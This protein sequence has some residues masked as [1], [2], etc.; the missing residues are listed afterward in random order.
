MKI[1]I[2]ED[3][4]DT[5]FGGAEKSMWDYIL[6]LK[7]EGIELHLIYD[8]KGD[9]L[10]EENIKVFKTIH[11]LSI[12]SP[13]TIGAIQYLKN[14]W[15][16][17]SILKENEID[18]VFTHVVHGFPFLK[19]SKYISNFKLVVYFKW[20]LP[21]TPQ[22]GRITAWGITC[23]DQYIVPNNFI[24]TYWKSNGL[25]NHK[26]TVVP[27]GIKRPIKP[28]NLEEDSYIQ[29]LV[30]LG[31]IYE[32]KGLHL[33]IES[34]SHFPSLKLLVA[35]YFSVEDN[36]ENLEYHKKIIGII[37]QL[38]LEDRVKFLGNIDDPMF[39]MKPENLLVVPSVWPE[40]QSRVLM[41]GMATKTP[42]IASDIGGIPEV[43]YP[44]QQ[45]VL[46]K[47]NLKSLQK[48]IKEVL[49]RETEDQ[50]L[51]SS[52]LQMVFKDRYAL[53][54]THEELDR[55]LLK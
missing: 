14:L 38:E 42:V 39:L 46:F 50:K 16:F 1:L 26:V 8:R 52:N 51:I 3:K 37:K 17:K 28:L 4:A 9:W 31:R 12:H 47:P 33:L 18:T 24:G 21:S 13:S 40:A 20:M 19:I 45:E 15:K 53:N 32:G 22:L 7:N 35:G 41:E 44:F 2:L 5:N 25:S 6:H 23:I 34:L 54:R 55:I 27:D 11:E 30:F 36:H 43:A 49:N 29:N 48:K 10:N